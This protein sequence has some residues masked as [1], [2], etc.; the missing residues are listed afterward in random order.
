MFKI[1]LI[2]ILSPIIL[3]VA[4]LAICAVISAGFE[5]VVKVAII[6]LIVCLCRYIFALAKEKES[7]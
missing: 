4:T 1:L 5:T 2:L 6:A 3:V 7:S